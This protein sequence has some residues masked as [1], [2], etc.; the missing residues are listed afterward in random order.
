MDYSEQNLVLDLDETLLYTCGT[1]DKASPEV[2]KHPGYYTIQTREGKFWGMKRPYLNKFLRYCGTRFA[3]IGFWSAGKEGYVNEIVRILDPPFQPAFIMN[4]THCDLLHQE[5]VSETGQ[6]SYSR[7][8]LKP[9]GTV[10]TNHPEFD[11]SNS[12]ILDDRE[13]YSSD[14]L[15][16]WILIPPFNPTTSQLLTSD[17]NYLLRLMEWFERDDVKYARNVLEINKNIFM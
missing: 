5:Q 12:F 10:F 16:N 11:R 6:V 7:D 9:L 15:L 1:G 8:L 17:D 13:D 14:N 3:K 4:Y 2:Q